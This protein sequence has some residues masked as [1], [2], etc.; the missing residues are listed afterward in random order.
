M[1]KT[2]LLSVACLALVSCRQASYYEESGSVFHTY[3]RIKYQSDRILTADIDAELQSFNLSLNPFNP[4]SILAK[5]NRNEDTPVDA[6]F[7]AVF[8]RA[9]E[10]SERSGG[11][12]DVTAAPLINMW[13]FGFERK[14]TVSSHV[15]DSLKTFVGYRKIRLEGNRVVKDDPRIMLNFS[16][17]AKGY[18]CDVVAAL[19]ER[20]GVKNY[21]IDIGGEVAVKGVNPGGECW[22]VG[23]AEPDEKSRFV[24]KDINMILRLCDR[25]GMATSGN[26]RNFYVKDGRKYAHTINPLT[27]YPSEQSILSATIVAPDCMTADA[28]ATAFMVMGADAA[29][30]MA[31][32]I[33]EIAYYLI[34]AGEDGGTYD[35]RYSDGMKPMLVK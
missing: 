9:M 26:Y 27:G 17:I 14:D 4:N 19:L 21:M 24:N 35:I 25:C 28:Y 3:F 16:A 22:R 23:I 29:C 12:F 20:K 34:C 31:E 2:L 7:T 5:V 33:P 32:N 1:K 18:A 11:L 6:W 10:V 30:R 8:N 13:G 15:V